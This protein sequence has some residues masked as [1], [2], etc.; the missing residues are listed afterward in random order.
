VKTTLSIIFAFFAISVGLYPMMYFVV[1]MSEGLLSSKPAALLQ[2]TLWPIAFYQHIFFGGIALLVGWSQF[3]KG[4]RKRHLKIHRL[5]G[6]IYMIAVLLSGTAGLYIAFSATGGIVSIT[7]FSGLAIAWLYTSAVAYFAIRK[8]EFDDHQ[9]WMIRSYSLCF[10]A[11]TLRLWLPLFQFGFGIGF[12]AAYPI[13]AWLCWV[14]N[15]ITAEVIVR[16]LKIQKLVK[17]A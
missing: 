16:N 12:M 7:G 1:D 3:M 10:A 8:K 17:P 15:L 2:S 4:I 5:T 9:Y 13:I 14:P 6:K 11:V